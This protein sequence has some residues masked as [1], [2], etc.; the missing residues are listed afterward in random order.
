[1]SDGQEGDI[2]LLVTDVVMPQ[3]SGR[4][5]AGR[6]RGKRPGMRVLYMSGYTGNKL[7][8]AVRQALNPAG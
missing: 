2:H 1:M 5:L 6:L 3:S 8:R 7:L 4:E